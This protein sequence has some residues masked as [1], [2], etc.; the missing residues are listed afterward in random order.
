MRSEFEPN[1]M[2]VKDKAET[3]KIL[4]DA[5]SNVLVE[6]D[7]KLLNHPLW[8]DALVDHMANAALMVMCAYFAGGSEAIN[9]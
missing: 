7:K 2:G 6:C 8:G 1:G 4:V 3:K 5:M 9:E